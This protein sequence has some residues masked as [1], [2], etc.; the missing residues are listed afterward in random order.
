MTTDLLTRL[1]AADPH[2][3]RGYVVTVT[4]VDT[5]TGTCTVDPGDGDP[6]ADV[7]YY[8]GTPGVGEVLV[9]LLFDDLLVVPA[10]GSGGSGRSSTEL[11][12]GINLNTVTTPGV[13]SQSQTAEATL[14]LNYPAA[15]A[16][17]L[18]VFDNSANTATPLNIMIWQRYS[19]YAHGSYPNYIYARSCL[20]GT[21][22]AWKRIDLVDGQMVL[23]GQTGVT[24]VANT[25]TKVA[26]TFPRAFASQPV[27]TVTANSAVPG[28]GVQEVTCANITTI[29]CDLYI[30][31][32][33]TTATELHWI[34]VGLPA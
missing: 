4:A 24:P 20:N 10:G 19:T 18:E 25:P 5:A 15:V 33:N 12:A 34:A 28:S 11:G 1:A 9:A 14:A 23:A 13:Y 29:G 31:R 27:V 22:N 17:M 30:Y 7:P 3:T 2:R 16:G 21:W 32:T 26:V 6:V 8:A